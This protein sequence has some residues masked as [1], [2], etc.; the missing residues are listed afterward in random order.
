M[1][2]LCWSLSFP[3]GLHFSG[4]AKAHL[5][6]G[7][8]ALVASTDRVCPGALSGSYMVFSEQLLELSSFVFF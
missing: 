4:P 8:S 7:M 5:V 1:A 3:A 6:Q 2:S